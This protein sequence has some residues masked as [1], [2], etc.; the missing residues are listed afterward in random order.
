[1][2]LNNCT[3][4]KDW[5][6]CAG[7]HSHTISY[8][9]EPAAHCPGTVR[10]STPAF[11]GREW[12]PQCSLSATAV[13]DQP[14]FEPGAQARGALWRAVAAQRVVRKAGQTAGSHPARCRGVRDGYRKQG[15]RHMCLS[16]PRGRGGPQQASKVFTFEISVCLRICADLVQ[17]A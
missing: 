8:G 3:S 13:R 2:A 1:M 15:L 12:F 17:Y 5:D 10:L 4:M 11:P 14:T 9:H 6:K 7:L 16:D